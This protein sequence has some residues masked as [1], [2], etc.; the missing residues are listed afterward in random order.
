MMIRSPGF[1]TTL[2]AIAAPLALA[3]PEERL[4]ILYPLIP[5]I[6]PRNYT[7]NGI[8]GNLC[9]RMPAAVTARVHGPR[10]NLNW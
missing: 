6:G 7:Q 8:R 4:K 1:S 2:S 3:H 9:S 10:R 5:P